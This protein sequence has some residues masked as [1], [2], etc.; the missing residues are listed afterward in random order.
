MILAGVV[1]LFL[2]ENG[3][4]LFIINEHHGPSFVDS[5]GLLLIITSWAC[6][7][8]SSIKRNKKIRSIINIKWV[9]FCICAISIGTV[10][11]IISLSNNS[12]SGWMPGA[13][14]AVAGYTVLFWAAF[15]SP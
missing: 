4:R 8:T 1:L 3:D 6:M 15:K 13:G 9:L 7:V 10:W 14:I 5:A 2:P 12:I 11:V